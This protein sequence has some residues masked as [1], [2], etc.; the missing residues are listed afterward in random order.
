MSVVIVTFRDAPTVTEEALKEVW[1]ALSVVW[2][3]VSVLSADLSSGRR[4]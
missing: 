1:L 3:A 4:K 2:H